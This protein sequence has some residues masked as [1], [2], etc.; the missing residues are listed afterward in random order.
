MNV[1][2]Q[3]LWIQLTSDRKRFGALCLMVL[4]GLLLW[5]RVILVSKPPQTAIAD[6]ESDGQT[7]TTDEASG[8]ETPEKTPVEVLLDG[9]T[10]RDPFRISSTH[11]PKPTSLDDKA[12]KTGK[13]G[14]DADDESVDEETLRTRQLQELADQLELEAVM[15]G[16]PMAIINGQTYQRGADVPAPGDT[17]ESFR[18]VEVNT[19]SV[20]LECEGRRFELHLRAPGGRSR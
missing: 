1:W 19:L 11:F 4:I 16:R 12:E 10:R 9:D 7:E 13:S 14:E 17:P 15:T 8:N 5:S 20:V 3:R 18:L 6:E 2:I